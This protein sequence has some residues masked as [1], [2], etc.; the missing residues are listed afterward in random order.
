MYHSQHGHHHT[1]SHLVRPWGGLVSEQLEQEAGVEGRQVLE[2]DPAIVD[3]PGHQAVASD[4]LGRSVLEQA[5]PRTV[6]LLE[7]GHWQR[8]GCHGVERLPCRNSRVRG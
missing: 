1:E 8:Q 2:P 3:V 5:F 4:A 7:S 6:N